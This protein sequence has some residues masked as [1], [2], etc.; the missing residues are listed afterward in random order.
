MKPNLYSI[1]HNYTQKPLIFK[2]L[3]DFTLRKLTALMRFITEKTIHFPDVHMVCH[4]T[5]SFKRKLYL[6]I[7]NYISN[8]TTRNIVKSHERKIGLPTEWWHQHYLLLWSSDL[9][10]VRFCKCTNHI[11]QFSHEIFH[12]VQT[13]SICF[14]QVKYSDLDEREKRQK[15]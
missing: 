14:N 4:N 11:A 2:S 7:H 10:R 5:I 13:L 3:T 9:G 6:Y 15:V 12:P 1:F 8:L